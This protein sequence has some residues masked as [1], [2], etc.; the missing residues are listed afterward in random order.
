MVDYDGWSS[1][2]KLKESGD[3]PLVIEKKRRFR[4]STTGDVSGLKLA[5]AMHIWSHKKGIC[6]C[7]ELGHTYHPEQWKAF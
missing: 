1:M 2:S 3:P 4:L 6:K 5:R 7:I